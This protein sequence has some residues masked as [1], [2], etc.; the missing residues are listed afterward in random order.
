M[1]YIHYIDQ[2]VNV[3]RQQHGDVNAPWYIAR[4]HQGYGLLWLGIRIRMAWAC[5]IGKADAVRFHEDDYEN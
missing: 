1:K 5:L 4:Q 3:Q 2:L